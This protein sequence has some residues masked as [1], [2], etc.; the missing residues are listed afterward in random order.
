[1]KKTLIIIGAILMTVMVTSCTSQK[2]YHDKPLG[3]PSGYRAHFPEMDSN[4]NGLVTW[5]EFKNRFPDTN[6]D[7]FTALDQNED[8]GIDHDE[9]HNFKKAHCKKDCHNCMKHHHKHQ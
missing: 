9:W 2:R 1:M 5:E 4:G 7:V 3:D 8:G 6:A